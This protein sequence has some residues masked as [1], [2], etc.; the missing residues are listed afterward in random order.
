MCKS[1]TDA[2]I[3]LKMAV[4]DL[5]ALKPTITDNATSHEA[6]KKV[7]HPQ[8]IGIL[9]YESRGRITCPSNL[10]QYF[11]ARQFSFSVGNEQLRRSCFY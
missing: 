10:A 9:K 7:C 4:G 1:P 5:A 8:T 6:E 2:G 3:I 11:L